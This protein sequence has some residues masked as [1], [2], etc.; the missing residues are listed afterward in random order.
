VG[1][2]GF[3]P[4][5]MSGAILVVSATRSV[6]QL[7]I[8]TPNVYGSSFGAGA[9]VSSTATVT[10]SGGIGSYTYS[11]TKTSGGAITANSASA[12]STTFAGTLALGE[13]L[14]AVYKCTVTDSTGS[15]A[16]IS[17]EVLLFEVS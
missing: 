8:N 17:V 6:I 13:A 16:E 5:V 11:W 15:T 2:L 4:L 1:C 9:A 3:R 12:A 7:T 14:E 10:P